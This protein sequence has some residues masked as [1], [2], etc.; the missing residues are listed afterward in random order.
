MGRAVTYAIR[1]RTRTFML[2]PDADPSVRTQNLVREYPIG[3]GSAGF[4]AIERERYRQDFESAVSASGPPTCM[5]D[6]R[7][8]AE[9]LYLS[10]SPEP[11]RSSVADRWYRN[12]LD[13]HD[14]L[15][16][17]R[18]GRIGPKDR[19]LPFERNVAIQ[20]RSRLDVTQLGITLDRL[21]NLVPPSANL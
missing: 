8:E 15:Y 17:G 9:A 1:D 3:R 11:F 19:W 21:N 16:G 2:D 7:L 13:R 14:F 5:K 20:L 4:D 6:V 10:L 12:T 18:P